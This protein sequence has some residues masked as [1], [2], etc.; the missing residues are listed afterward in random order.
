MGGAKI[1]F[2]SKHQA[3]TQSAYRSQILRRRRHRAALETRIR[4]QLRRVWRKSPRVNMGMWA[5]FGF[6]THLVG[7]SLYSGVLLDIEGRGVG[8]F[9]PST[10]G[11]TY[12]RGDSG[13]W[14]AGPPSRRQDQEPYIR[15]ILEMR[16]AIRNRDQ[17][18][19]VIQIDEI[20]IQIS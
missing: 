7:Y 12:A 2:G 14:T 19:R 3:E 16:T 18:T 4:P 20:R 8:V 15:Q 9:R 11:G 13:I 17:A 10:N 6:F 1:S 5:L